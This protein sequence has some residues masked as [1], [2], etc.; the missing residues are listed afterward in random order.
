[1]LQQVAWRGCGHPI[2]GGIQGQV[3]W[4]PGQSDLVSENLAHGRDVRTR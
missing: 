4:D 3:G 1:M 2:S